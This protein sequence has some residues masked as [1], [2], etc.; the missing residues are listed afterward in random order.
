MSYVSGLLSFC[1]GKQVSFQLVRQYDYFYEHET[2]S[3][4]KNRPATEDDAS[5]AASH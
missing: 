3:F 2:V 4:I 5:I 1:L